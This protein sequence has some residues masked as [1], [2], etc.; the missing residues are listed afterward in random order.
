M[1]DYEREEK[2][3]VEEYVTEIASIC[4]MGSILLGP[5]ISIHI[6]SGITSLKIR[7]P[8]LDAQT[9]ILFF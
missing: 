4:N 8:K 2:N 5:L 9:P 1:K 3:S 7:R 6:P